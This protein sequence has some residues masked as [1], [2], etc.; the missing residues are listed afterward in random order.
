MACTCSRYSLF[1]ALD[2]M[3][4]S[5]RQRVVYSLPS[6]F[7]LTTCGLATEESQY[8][9]STGF[10]STSAQI[11]FKQSS[12]LK[13]KAEANEQRTTMNRDSDQKGVDGRT[14]CDVRHNFILQQTHHRLTYMSHYFPESVRTGVYWSAIFF[15]L[16]FTLDIRLY[17]R[18]GYFLFSLIS[19]NHTNETYKGI[20]CTITIYN[21][22]FFVFKALT[23]EIKQYETQLTK[24]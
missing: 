23:M 20:L 19:C 16:L 2:V 9:T 22:D 1:R 13:Q 5:H 18:S 15:L 17:C 14:C 6:F 21:I 11:S 12:I 10:I 24:I 7:L 4:F 8:S 3:P